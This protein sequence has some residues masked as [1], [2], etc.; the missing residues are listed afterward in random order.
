MFAVIFAYLMGI[1]LIGNST[2]VSIPA[3]QWVDLISGVWFVI[4]GSIAG[5]QYANRD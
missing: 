3:L 5:W 4:A 2:V 1:L